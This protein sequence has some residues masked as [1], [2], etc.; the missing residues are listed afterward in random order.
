MNKRILLLTTTLL[1][2][3]LGARVPVTYDQDTYRSLPALEHGLFR[4]GKESVR[5]TIEKRPSKYR[6][7]ELNDKIVTITFHNG[8]QRKYVLT[9]NSLYRLDEDM[10]M[11]E[12]LSDMAKTL[13]IFA[14]GGIICSLIA[15]AVLQSPSQGR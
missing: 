15:R 7:V 8:T 4:I 6:F 5:V 12:T 10:S 14:S 13:A 1:S 3:T 9:D 11:R 2:T